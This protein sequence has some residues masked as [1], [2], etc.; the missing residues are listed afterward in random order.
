[1]ATLFVWFTSSITIAGT[2]AYSIVV[3]C[4]VIF[5]FLSF[6]LPIALGFFAIGGPKWPHMGPWNLGIVKFRIVAVLS[7]VAMALLLFIGVQPPND[8]A[9]PITIGFLILAL[10]IWVVFERRRFQGPP[11]GDII[12]AREGAIQAAE[13]AVGEQS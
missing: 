3:S 1:L 2:P 7:V 12:A 4:T 5:L 13:E 10:I 9:L 8:Y 11:T 6:T